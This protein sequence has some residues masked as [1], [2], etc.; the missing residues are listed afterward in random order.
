MP[1]DKTREME[2][3][4]MVRV[5]LKNERAKKEKGENKRK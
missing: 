3:K 4:Y 5:I 2:E 1:L